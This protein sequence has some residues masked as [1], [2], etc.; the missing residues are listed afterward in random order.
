M[1]NTFLAF[2]IILVIGYYFKDKIL[3]G[4][5]TSYII[6]EPSI[7]KVVDIE[8]SQN[9]FDNK[10]CYPAKTGQKWEG[11]PGSTACLVNKEKTT[12]EEKQCDTYH[13]SNLVYYP[14][15]RPWFRYIH[16]LK[17]RAEYE[18]IYPPYW[19]THYDPNIT[20]DIYYEKVVADHIMP[21]SYKT[22]YIKKEHNEN[23]DLRQELKFTAP[24]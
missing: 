10:V 14:R 9:S 18:R 15:Y 19:N 7:T 23:F 11:S 8:C 2:L 6:E 22:P 12:D 24:E 20:S 4:F 21:L 13:L 5:Q 16:N 17:T 3:E 1:Q